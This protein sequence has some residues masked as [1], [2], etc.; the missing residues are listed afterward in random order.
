[1]A[2]K[3]L[4][5]GA[6]QRERE[7]A[8]LRRVEGVYDASTRE[9]SALFIVPTT[10]RAA[11]LRR[12]VTS[13]FGG[14]C[15]IPRVET[16]DTL[17]SAHA[18]DLSEPFRWV[19]TEARALLVRELAGGSDLLGR[20]PLTPGLARKVVGFL[21]AMAGAWYAGGP[22][23]DELALSV[24]APSLA[25]GPALASFA[26]RYD[27]ALRRRGLMD[28]RR[29]TSLL[30]AAWGERGF[31]ARE[32]ML[33][34]DEFAF[35]LPVGIRLFDVMAR[36][37]GE[38]VVTLPAPESGVESIAADRGFAAAT[39]MAEWAARDALVEPV[40]ASDPAPSQRLA[41][42][43]FAPDST[44]DRAFGD[45]R[46]DTP[47]VVA[48]PSRL[49]EVRGVARMIRVDMGDEAPDA[50]D[51]TPY[52]VVVS[53]YA[54]YRRLVEETFREYGLP[55]NMGRG[56]PL[57]AT[58][59]LRLARKILLTVAEPDAVWTI[60]E[61]MDVLRHAR[62][63]EADGSLQ[64]ACALAGAPYDPLDPALSN[65]RPFWLARFE[66]LVLRAGIA[67]AFDASDWY[68]RLTLYLRH[69]DPRH[70][71]DDESAHFEEELR[72]PDVEVARDV[73]VVGKFVN[74]VAALSETAT[75]REFHDA[76]L[77]LL[78]DYGLSGPDAASADAAPGADGEF[79]AWQAFLELLRQM[80]AT[81]GALSADVSDLAAYVCQS[82]AAADATVPPV[83]RENAVSIMS[84]E[85]SVG[86]THDRLY[87]VGLLEGEFPSATPPNFLVDAELR[88]AGN[89]TSRLDDAPVERFLFR[90]ALTNATRVTLTYPRMDG[91][92]AMSPS[93]FLD[94]VCAALGLSDEDVDVDPA[95]DAG[96][97]CAREALALSGRGGDVAA[98]HLPELPHRN[99]DLLVRVAAARESVARWSDYDTYLPSSNARVNERLS[100]FTR[101]ELS[102][103]QFDT[104]AKCPAKL[105]YA[106][107]LR[108]GAAEAQEPD[109]AANVRGIVI[110]SIL[111]KFFSRGG[112]ASDDGDWVGVTARGRMLACAR[113]A[114][115]DYD[116]QYPNLYW[117]EE[118]RALVQGLDD[119]EAP[120]GLLAGF[121]AAEEDE[122]GVAFEGGYSRGRF[123]EVAFGSGDRKDARVRLPAYVIPRLDG[124]GDIHIKGYVDRVDVDEETGRYVVFDYK[125]GAAPRA[126]DALD[127]LNFQLAIYMDA[128]SE[129]EGF[130]R[131]AGGVFYSVQRPTDVKRRE[132]LAR[133]QLARNFRGSPPG[134]L[135][136]DAFDR[137]RELTRDRV[138]EVESHMRHGRFPVTSLKPEKAGCPRCDY[139]DI[140]R[141]RAARQRRMATDQPQYR[142][143][144]FG[145]D[146]RDGDDA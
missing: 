66:R 113:R 98:R 142:P 97:M 57:S 115:E 126:R 105:F 141:L 59:L 94:D 27:A 38:V 99:V 19:D 92:R 128:L 65:V 79:Q 85:Q 72:A 137:F 95:A 54:P 41:G 55:T 18:A 49:E 20:G 117:E 61:L 103:T 120:Q 125:T 17:L 75:A 36:A 129:R 33:V 130:S 43:I 133:R 34:L 15:W 101:G 68:V 51:F 12:A 119:T 44:L 114:F 56:A 26:A 45:G 63:D 52:T 140:C 67:D 70:D 96:V 11:A 23:V 88:L 7:C 14:K 83:R 145:V 109:V 87:M 22:D 53:S 91:G 80:V 111:E 139:R 118:K 135:D 102:A 40:G 112:S 104:Y 89:V 2:T 121:L 144:P 50:A 84:P 136:D 143:E 48:Y 82:L 24:S 8:L 10:E 134:L 69:T 122:S 13:H 123:N 110:H 77:A 74:R 6:P 39:A 58:P 81:C 5:A 131:P 60:S 9:V 138:R 25:Y 4:I 30:L 62:F 76:L 32:R 86:L 132:P 73:C 29:L 28:R 106:H 93:P 127:G 35:A 21:D 46:G 16:L 146:A 78:R 108:I 107:V 71:A 42:A 100:E 90:E 37:F 64:E 116:A 1:M 124:D 3:H 31:P 47:R